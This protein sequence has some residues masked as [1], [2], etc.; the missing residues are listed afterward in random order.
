MEYFNQKEEVLDIQLTQYGKYLLSQGRFKPLY[1][2][3][4]DDDIIYDMEAATAEEAQNDIETRITGSSLRPKT[5][6]VFRGIET[7]VKRAHKKIKSGEAEMGSRAV[8]PGPENLALA[9]PL[10]HSDYTSRY[11]PS[12]SLQVKQGKITDT[13]DVY[14]F[15]NKNTD[16]IPLVQ[17]P[18]INMDMVYKTRV[19]KLSVE[20]QN[21]LQAFDE[22][23]LLGDSFFK[24]GQITPFGK[25]GQYIALEEENIVID[26]R[27]MNVLFKN[28]NF[29]IEVFKIEEYTVEE[30]GEDITREDLVPLKFSDPDDLEEELTA[31]HVEYYFDVFVDSEIITEEPQQQPGSQYIL[32]ENISEDCD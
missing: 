20:E 1:Y 24:E 4:F 22:F 6:Y 7:D 19:K 21:E 14:T 29:D 3:F 13:S 30:A 28:K 25:D 18:Q 31:E 8:T 9:N 32:P 26:V 5:Q 17:T 10:G 27:E 23:D 16:Y 15:S 2:A 11:R 12:W